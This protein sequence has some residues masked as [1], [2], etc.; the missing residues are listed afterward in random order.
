MSVIEKLATSLGRKD[1]VPNQ[2]LAREIASKNDNK[3]VSE[4]IDILKTTKDKKIQSDCIKTLY[5]IGYIKPELIAEYYPF[6]I[7]LLKS[8][9]NRLV[10]GAMIALYTISKMKPREI[11]ENLS[12]ILEAIQK[13]SVITKDYGVRILINL[14]GI[15]EFANSAF[16]L[17]MDQLR[18]CEPKQLP[19]YAEKTLPVI[20]AENQ[21][22]F[23][24]LLEERFDELEKDSQK[25]RIEKVLR[26]LK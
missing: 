25:R 12:E 24:E 26:K 8:R 23:I 17:L 10:W 3:S 5:E 22:I 4:L 20:N 1:D 6:F 2:E 7:E 11:F 18:K 13:G 21:R 16:D 19:L 9:N 15:S 14:S